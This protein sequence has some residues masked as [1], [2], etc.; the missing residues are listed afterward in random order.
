MYTN[1]YYAY[2]IRYDRYIRYIRVTVRMPTLR[3][4]FVKALKNKAGVTV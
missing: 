4:S 3:L 2:H 1:L